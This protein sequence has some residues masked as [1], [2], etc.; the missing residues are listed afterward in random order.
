MDDNIGVDV[1]TD[2]LG[3][4]QGIDIDTDILRGPRG[5]Q[6]LQG[7]PGPKGDK[8]DTPQKGID[9]FTEEEKE[10]FKNAVVEES[11]EDIKTT[12]IADSKIE[13]NSHIEDKKTELNNYTTEQE[14]NLKTELDNYTDTKKTELDTKKAD[15]ETEM[16]NTKDTLIQDITQHSQDKIK[17]FDT[18]ATNKTNAFN[19]NYTKKL[20]ELN[21]VGGGDLEEKIDSIKG[22]S[23]NDITELK[24]FGESKQEEEPDFLNNKEV[25]LQVIK[26]SIEIVLD[27]GLEV[28]D[29]NYKS[30]SFKFPLQKPLIGNFDFGNDYEKDILDLLNEKEVHSWNYIKTSMNDL[31]WNSRQIQ[32]A[33]IFGFGTYFPH[34][35]N[36]STVNK[37]NLF[38]QFTSWSSNT[39]FS[40]NGNQGPTTIFNIYCP[41]EFG[42]LGEMTFEEALEKWKNLVQDKIL[43]LTYPVY[44]NNNKY[45]EELQFT[46]EQKVVAKE[47]KDL[48]MYEGYTNISANHSLNP[49]TVLNYNESIQTIN[50]LHRRVK[51]LENDVVNYISE[52]KV[53]GESVQA[54]EPDFLNDIEVPLQI[55]KD[56]L[57]IQVSNG[58]DTKT[59]I[60]PLQKPLVGNFDFIDLEKDVLDLLR[61]KEVHHWNYINVVASEQNWKV[62]QKKYMY[63]NKLQYAN[64]QCPSHNNLFPYVS[65]AAPYKL[66]VR[67]GGCVI[68]LNETHFGSTSSMT[69]DEIITKW[70]EMLV[71]KNLEV[72][73]YMKVNSQSHTETLQFTEE[74]KTIARQI[75]D[76]IMYENYT[77]VS[78]NHALNPV[79]TLN[80]SK[81]N[82]QA[83]ENLQKQVDEIIN[84]LSTSSTSAMLLE[85]LENDL[86]K[87]VL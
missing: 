70:K 7:K 73:Y 15:L 40:I 79:T 26:D 59:F 32:Q 78:I 3:G 11:K 63:W 9:Y 77:N 84:L 76:L 6:G 81:S 37:N 41:H 1:D 35:L 13:L 17:E 53:E 67:G 51:T 85:S 45:T 55:I 57:E 10:E 71:G 58:T 56:N 42:V 72:A 46:E 25:P 54:E 62:D 48:I 33:K 12:V 47:I 29:S 66:C 2:V 27:N 38:M 23:I 52:L 19:E 44:E 82:K 83:I 49:E 80:Y 20:E 61:E 5:P 28:T 86:E 65:F 21:N 43:E 36:Y 39:Y 60:F 16:C 68:Q 30:K 74:Q 50:S 64:D 31:T 75:K 14:N 87:E 8:G 34:L 4:S 24:I 18:N 22:G 69:V